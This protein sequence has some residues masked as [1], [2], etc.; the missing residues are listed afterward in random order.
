[1]D[2]GGPQSAAAADYAVNP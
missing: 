1:L 2:D